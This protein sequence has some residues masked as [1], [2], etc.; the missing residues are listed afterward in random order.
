[1]A[2]LTEQQRDF[3]DK[4]VAT[5]CT[6]TEAARAANYAIPHVEASR[7]IRKPHVLAA[8]REARERVV[9]GHSANLA[10]A[11]LNEIMRDTQAPASARVSAARTV[12]EVSGDFDGR[13]R[14]IASGKALQEMSVDELEA[15][16]I[17]LDSAIVKLSG[18]TVRH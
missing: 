13:G 16:I 1:M 7:L 3:V 15:T 14:D 8:I 4:L 18:P 11:T 5:G 9:S 6:P 17:K 2:Q 12:L 10:V